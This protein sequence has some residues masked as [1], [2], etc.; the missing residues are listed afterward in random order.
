[1]RTKTKKIPKNEFRYN[2]KTEHVNYIFEED[3]KKYKAK[4]IT[5]KPTTFG[6]PNMPLSKNPE[7]LPN[8]ERKQKTA[9]IRNGTIVD[10]KK[11][12]AKKPIKKFDF[13]KEDF[14]KVKSTIRNYK[15]VSK[16]K[17]NK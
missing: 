1:M 17:K 3:G 16:N 11:S 14:P 9:Y 13:A 8:G 12:F 6:K 5:S 4:G 7:H 10:N 2:H 15:K